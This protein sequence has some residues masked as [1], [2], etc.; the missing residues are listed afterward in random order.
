M[1]IR[2]IPHLKCAGRCYRLGIDQ[3]NRN[4][5]TSS[6]NSMRFHTQTN[7]NT[8]GLQQ[9]KLPSIV[10]LRQ[11]NLKL[12]LAEKRRVCSGRG[13][14]MDAIRAA[15]HLDS[16]KDSRKERWIFEQQDPPREYK[17]GEGKRTKGCPQVRL[18]QP[19]DEV[20]F[21]RAP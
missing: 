3:A 14:S 8:N 7:T 1:F 10:F 5:I 17:S 13:S 11:A 9:I 4:H 18:A 6:C 20:L 12:P 15:I 19:R 21:S 16:Q 2:H